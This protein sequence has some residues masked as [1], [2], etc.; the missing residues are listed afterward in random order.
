[1]TPPDYTWLAPLLHFSDSAL[2][3]G[4]YAHSLGL[5]GLCQ[6]GVVHDETTLRLFLC[7]DVVTSLTAVDFPLTARAY[8]AAMDADSGKLRDLDQLSWALRPTA[9]LRAASSKVGRQ[10]AKLYAKTWGQ[11]TP[12]E[13]FSNLLHSQSAIVMGVILAEQGVPLEA[14]LSSA[15]YQ[16]YATLMQASLKLLPIGPTIAQ[17]LLHEALGTVLPKIPAAIALPEEEIGTFN[18]LWDIASSQHERVEARLFLS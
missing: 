1:M 2:P 3:V 6:M 13:Q 12:P 18:P 14:G 11:D 4:S 7:Q 17:A 8:Q 5:E 16:I 15:A 9:E 10:Q